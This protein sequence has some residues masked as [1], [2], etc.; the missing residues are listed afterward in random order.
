[1]SNNK[2]NTQNLD[3]SV[4]NYTIF[5]IFKYPSIFKVTGVYISISSVENVK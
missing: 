4:P 5:Y 1:M 3:V 2:P